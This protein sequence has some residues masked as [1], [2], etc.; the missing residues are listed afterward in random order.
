MVFYSLCNTIRSKY[1]PYL[2]LS[3][4][5]LIINQSLLGVFFST[6][7]YYDMSN[8]VRMTVLRQF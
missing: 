7:F 4:N 8:C 5:Y 3:H 6:E 2:N 1:L